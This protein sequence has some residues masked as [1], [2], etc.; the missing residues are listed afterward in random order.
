MDY[1]VMEA[2]VQT[3]DSAAE[4]YLLA[5]QRDYEPDHINLDVL[6]LL[7]SRLA[8]IL[9]EE[10]D[11]LESMEYERLGALQPEKRSLVDA[12]EKQ[13]RVLQRRPQARLNLDDDERD[14]LEELIM[15][16]NE[17]MQ[18]NHKRLLVAREVNQ[19]VVQ[20]ITELVQEQSRQGLYTNKGHHV[21]DPS[22]SLSMSQSI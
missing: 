9:A 20:A 21:D 8:Q 13:Q 12:L 18:E 17:I 2:E 16:F 7:I 19:R 10:V 6:K 4:A 15:I 22:V 1:D 5:T 11:V 14:D 3:K